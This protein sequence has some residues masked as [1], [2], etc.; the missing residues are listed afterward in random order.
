MAKRVTIEM[1]AREAGVSRGTV[2]R[3]I[4]CRPHVRE[5]QYRKVM[6]A[7]HKLG[8][9][10]K[11][12]QAAAL[13]IAIGQKEVCRLGV[14]L[15][16]RN[17]WYMKEVLRGIQ[18]AQTQLADYSVEILTEQCSS[19][20][21]P[22]EVIGLMDSLLERGVRGIVMCVMDFE[23]V[24]RKINELSAQGIPVATFYSDVSSDRLFFLGKDTVRT[25]RVAGALMAR[26]IAPGGKILIGMGNKEIRED[27]DRADA[28]IN[29][30]KPYGFTEEMFQLIETFND[31]TLTYEKVRQVLSSGGISGIYLAHHSL[32]ACMDAIRAEGGDQPPMVIFGD[33]NERVHRYLQSGE[34]Q[35]CV[36]PNIYMM[37]YRPLILLKEH[38]LDHRT[39][40]EKE[41][42]TP[43]EIICRENCR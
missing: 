12:K 21:Y 30:M 28:F 26:Y 33:M 24:A 31:Y 10:P 4:N 11:R 19:S 6:E 18:D 41:L 42:Y 25:S 29:A 20:P 13:G 2:D 39:P 32:T 1:V 7:I 35:F 16:S 14:I 36:I 23:P 40:E 15:P 34:L 8:Y 5:D 43:T 9:E 22:E 27:V 17:P 3:V 38:V 37:G